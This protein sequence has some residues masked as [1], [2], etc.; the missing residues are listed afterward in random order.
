[1]T[2]WHG[3]TMFLSIMCVGVILPYGSCIHVV[4]IQEEGKIR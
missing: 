2:E 1:M 4:D 3:V